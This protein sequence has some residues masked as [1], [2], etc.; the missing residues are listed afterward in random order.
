MY[1]RMLDKQAKPVKRDVTNNEAVI[2]LVK[3]FNTPLMLKL[4]VVGISQL[5]I[6]IEEATRENILLSIIS[7]HSEEES[8][9][10]ESIA[11]EMMQKNK[12]AIMLADSRYSKFLSCCKELSIDIGRIT[13]RHRNYYDIFAARYIFRYIFKEVKEPEEFGIA[14]WEVF[15][16]N[17]CPINV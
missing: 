11:F 1:E 14:M 8:W 5:G 13:F 7:Q 6:P 4:L 17:I 16:N 2:D 12:M 9:A 10:L 3:I 15:A